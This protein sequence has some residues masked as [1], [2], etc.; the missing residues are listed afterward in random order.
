MGVADR[1]CGET[2]DEHIPDQGGEPS[3]G[4]RLSEATEIR[5]ARGRHLNGDEDAYPTSP[6]AY[7]F[8]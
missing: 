2:D 5:E 6:S 1:A 8:V 7:D 4:L 3:A